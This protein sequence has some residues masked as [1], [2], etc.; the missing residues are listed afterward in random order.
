L[1]FIGVEKTTSMN[2]KFLIISVVI[3]SGFAGS[4][5]AQQIVQLTPQEFSQEE[6]E[7]MKN[8]A[9]LITM[10]GGTFLIEFFPED[11]PNT[12]HNFLKLVESGYYDG[13][14]F[15][16]II[17][18]FMI[19]TGDPNT[20]D[21]DSDRS[22][23]GQGEPGYRISE[24]F[25]TFQHDRGIV[26]MARGDHKDSAGSQFFITHIPTPW[27]DGKHSVFG[28][29]AEGMSIVNLI[30]QG[31]IIESIS[32]ERIGDQA[33]QFIADEASFQEQIEKVNTNLNAKQELRQKEFE[34]YVTTS[35]PGIKKSNLGYFTMVNK[36]GNDK[37]PNEGQ[38]VSVDVSFKADNGQ[39]LREA[40]SPI[41]FIL[42]SGQIISF[43]DNNIRDMSI[44]EVRTIIV[45]YEAVFGDN[46]SGDIP[47]ESILIFE[48]ELLSAEDN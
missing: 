31:D 18:G 22:L 23:W 39:I 15:H 37:Q 26:S 3:L 5:F 4:A 33:N 8:K 6:I 17:P 36:S 11:A 24:E 43:I 34:N 7:E 42:G 27:L 13:I 19:Q 1:A 10:N 9:V 21:P 12:V 29:V 35:Y 2:F 41:E 48:L 28:L 14:V 44:G 46:P 32:I 45:T 30:E 20:K 47:Q 25:S 40:G 16:R 38:V